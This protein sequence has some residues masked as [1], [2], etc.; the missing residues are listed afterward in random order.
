LEALDLL[1]R[2]RNALV[3]RG[4]HRNLENQAKTLE[5]LV[6]RRT[7]E[8]AWTQIRI[9]HCL[10]RASDYRDN[11]TG[12]HAVRVG[13]YAHII[14]EQLG[15]ERRWSEYIMLAAMLHDVGKIGIPDRILL[16]PGRLDADEFRQMQEHCQFGL[17]IIA[18]HLHEELFPLLPID[19]EMMCDS[20]LLE[21]ASRI[22]ATHHE[23]WDGSGYPHG[24]KGEE[25]PLEGRIT[26]VADVFDALGST[27]PYKPAFAVEACRDMILAGV[28]T[29]FDPQVVA[30][31]LA[32]FDDILAV[33]E[34]LRD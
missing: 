6:R 15:Q 23:W 1:P 24:L 19:S 33:V 21:L 17:E 2:V 27:R 32:R 5:Q 10:A 30:A 8:L 4:H 34:Q 26:A 3:L 31:F 9:I 7:A 22:A 11:E 20:P 16:K 14:S 25:I 13:R 12:R 29:H 28:G 18:P